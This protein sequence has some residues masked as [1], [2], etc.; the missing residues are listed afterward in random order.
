[1][2]YITKEK[3]RKIES[4]MTELIIKRG[5]VC[6]QKNS[7][8]NMKVQ[9]SPKKFNKLFKNEAEI[10][11]L[12]RDSEEFPIKAIYYQGKIKH[13]TIFKKSLAEKYYGKQKIKEVGGNINGGN[14]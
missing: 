8:E 13:F 3:F 6:I 2:D 12:P 4:L 14:N 9:Y 11:L 1:M 10:E 5:L 7:W